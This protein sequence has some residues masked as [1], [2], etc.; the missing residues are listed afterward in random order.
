MRGAG[1]GVRVSSHT[2]KGKER[3]RRKPSPPPPS[4]EHLGD[5][6]EE[7]GKRS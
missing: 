2:C 5:E 3:M 1:G 7:L 6:I 4:P